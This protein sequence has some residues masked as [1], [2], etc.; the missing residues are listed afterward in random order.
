MTEILRTR[1]SLS[2]A[3]IVLFLVA[4]LAVLLVVLAPRDFLSVTPGSQHVTDD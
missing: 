2:L 3:S 4:Y 1:R